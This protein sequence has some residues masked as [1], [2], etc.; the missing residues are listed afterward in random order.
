MAVHVLKSIVLKNL[1][2]AQ[3]PFANVSEESVYCA[4]P[5]VKGCEKP[6]YYAPPFYYIFLKKLFIVPTLL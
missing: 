1:S 5:F 3:Q 4:H 6:I 2:W